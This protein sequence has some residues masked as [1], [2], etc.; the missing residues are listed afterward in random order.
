[1]SKGRDFSDWRGG[2]VPKQYKDNYDNIVWD[3][4]DEE[5]EEEKSEGS[6]S[7]RLR[8]GYEATIEGTSG[9]YRWR[10]TDE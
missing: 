2:V 1:M 10:K 7:R 3:R 4:S 5:K 9:R 6:S 8:E